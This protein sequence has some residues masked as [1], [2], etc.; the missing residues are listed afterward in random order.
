M[1][2]WEG[3]TAIVTG[4]SAGIGDAIVRDLVKYGINVVALA[5]RMD[6][7]ESLRDQLKDEPGKVIPIKCDVSDK[8]SIDAAFEEIDKQVGTLQILVNNAGIALTHGMFGDD[9]DK[10]DEIIS[11][12]INTNFLGLVRVSRKAYKLMKKS[13]DYGII[14]NIGSI[15]GHSA[16]FDYIINVYPGTKF[17]VRAVTESMRQELNKLKDTKIR[18]CEIS[19]G[20]VHT[21][22]G[23]DSLNSPEMKEMI[24]SGL[25]PILKGS[26]ISQTVLFMLMTPYE[27]NI[28]E[29]IVKPVG[30][31]I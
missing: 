17:A 15:A 8:A 16:S 18:V 29:M 9:D 21:E 3:K 20:G 26:D 12:T 31:R 7:L 19:P 10:T 24:E 13:E 6:R 30:E 11:S 28:T 22:I 1:D 5:R 25:V 2:K 4:A 14:I 27:V 23:G